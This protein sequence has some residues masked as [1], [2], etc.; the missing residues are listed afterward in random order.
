MIFF[1]EVDDPDIMINS[2][3]IIFSLCIFDYRAVHEIELERGHIFYFDI[4]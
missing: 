1:D 2:R 3:N 4:I